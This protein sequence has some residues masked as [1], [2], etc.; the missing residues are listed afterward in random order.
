MSTLFAKD[1]QFVAETSINLFMEGLYLIVYI[2]IEVFFGI[3]ALTKTRTQ[4]ST[5]FYVYNTND[6]LIKIFGLKC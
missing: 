6:I 3:H 4:R 1:V 2:M 5:Y